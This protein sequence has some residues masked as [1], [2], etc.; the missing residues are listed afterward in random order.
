MNL[1]VNDPEAGAQDPL[2]TG[3]ELDHLAKLLEVAR[4]KLDDS[5]AIL[6]LTRSFLIGRACCPARCACAACEDSAAAIV[7][8]IDE[9]WPSGAPK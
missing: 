9:M 3:S 4:L 2:P 7:E 6:A 8:A 1:A 5:H